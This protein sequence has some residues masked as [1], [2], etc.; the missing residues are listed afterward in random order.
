MEG[1]N[2]AGGQAF[3][4]PLIRGGPAGNKVKAVSSRQALSYHLGQAVL[5]LKGSNNESPGW[6]VVLF[7]VRRLLNSLYRRMRSTYVGVKLF[8]SRPYIPPDHRSP[9]RAD[10]TGYRLPA[11]RRFRSHRAP[12]LWRWSHRHCF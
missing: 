6:T 4:K 9:P 3:W 12:D 7:C 10:R 1:P 8:G 11:W 5:G 2:R